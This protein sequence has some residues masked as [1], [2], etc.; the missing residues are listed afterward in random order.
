MRTI[1]FVFLLFVGVL[2]ADVQGGSQTFN[3]KILNKIN[4][5][6][7]KLANTQDE[8]VKKRLEIEKK[9]LIDHLLKRLKEGDFA[10]FKD[11][12]REA[13]YLEY[14]KALR[15]AKEQGDELGVMTAQMQ[16]YSIY[17]ERVFELFL[18]TVHDYNEYLKPLSAY[19]ALF[20]Q[21]SESMSF[22]IKNYKR[23]YDKLS[24]KKEPTSE[25][26][27]YLRVYEKFD[28]RHRVYQDIFYVIASNAYATLETNSIITRFGI[29][30]LIVYLDEN[31]SLASYNE[32]C[33][34]WLKITIGQL[35]VAVGI[36]GLIL[37]F[38]SLVVDTVLFGLGKVLKKP[39]DD[40]EEVS[41]DRF[42]QFLDTSLR[43]PIRYFVYLIAV[44][45]ALRIVFMQ[46]NN[47]SIVNYFML[48]YILLMVWALFKMINNFV[49]IYSGNVLQRYPNVR[50]EMVNF[51][52]NFSKILVVVIGVLIVLSNM[53]Y[54]VS[55]IV[56]SLGI[57][58]LAIAFAARETIANIFGSISVILDNIFTQ[59]DWVVVD[60]IEGTVVDIGMRST[61]I[62]TFDN[63]MIY[64]PNAT[65]ASAKVRNWSKRMLGR[66]IYMKLG[67]TYDSDPKALEQ[68]VEDIREMLR[69]HPDIADS[70]AQH[71]METARMTKVVSR[72][73]EYGI[74][75]TLLVYLDGFSDSS[76]DIMIY[77]FSKSVEWQKWLEVKQDV[78]LKIIAIFEKNGLSFAFPSQSVYW[79]N[80]AKKPLE[81]MQI[82]P[83]RVT[84]ETI[85]ELKS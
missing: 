36:F 26:R 11:D 40:G 20:I 35:I 56:A 6:D 59:G 61:K 3:I 25:E 8:G 84:P 9:A 50:G 49:L 68:A 38:K 7:Y 74:K 39:Q 43:Q 31:D 60:N 57:G 58:G 70:T 67:A 33:K 62:R 80:D 65:M 63:S 71:E 44:D 22:S 15:E 83:E 72:D 32:L 82:A 85:K 37:L 29:E 4:L 2:Q 34:R 13:L 78:I 66:R 24:E 23:L 46:E 1:V 17:M 77:C 18:I 42:R 52:V 79:Q 14:T 47:Q 41:S 55:G 81:V 30:K 21:Y 16:I 53:G 27:K 5:L 48:G 75:K 54:D 12:D 76:I 10:T 64:V 69:T 45:L 51:F 19:K 73:L 28:D